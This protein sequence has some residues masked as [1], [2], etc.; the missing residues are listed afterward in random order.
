M[1]RCS[2]EVPAHRSP[3][4]KSRIAHLGRTGEHCSVVGWRATRGALMTPTRSR[5]A[6]HRPATASPSRRRR[7]RARRRAAARLVNGGGDGCPVRWLDDRMLPV[8]PGATGWV[9]EEVPRLVDPAHPRCRRSAGIGVVALREGPI[10]VRDLVPARGAQDAKDGV[11]I[12]V[13]H[14][15]RRIHSRCVGSGLVNSSES[16]IATICRRSPWRAAGRRCPREPRSIGPESRRLSCHHATVRARSRSIGRPPAR[17]R[18]RRRRG[19]RGPQ[20]WRATFQ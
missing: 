6:R 4:P 1:T 7:L 3:R 19:R 9:G 13:G 18:F 15:G 20:S 10:R 16:S 14:D 17:H 11:R 8:P 2:S 12:D 5:S